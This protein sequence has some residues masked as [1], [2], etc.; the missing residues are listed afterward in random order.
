M[1][2]AP[3]MLTTRDQLHTTR[4]SPRAKGTKARTRATA[5]RRQPAA[6]ARL[7]FVYRVAKAATIGFFWHEGIVGN[8]ASRPGPPQ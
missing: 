1:C 4:S 8:G 3:T 7:L 2:S 5:A 6:G